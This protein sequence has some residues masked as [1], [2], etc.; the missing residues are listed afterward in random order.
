MRMK[1]VFDAMPKVCEGFI[2]DTDVTFT[3]GYAGKA[4]ALEAWIGST[5]GPHSVNI[6]LKS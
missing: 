5:F 3:C 2:I 4:G 1:G 6:W